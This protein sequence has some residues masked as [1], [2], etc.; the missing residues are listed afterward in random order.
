MASR[1]KKPIKIAQLRQKLDLL[2][3][4]GRVVG[5]AAFGRLFKSDAK[6][7][8]LSGKTIRLWVDGEGTRDR[9]MVPEHN[10]GRFVEIFQK[11]LPGSDPT[12]NI[13]VTDQPERESSRIC[14]SVNR[15]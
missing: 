3:E 8:G 7:E 6:P 1:Y 11:N 9:N 10:F 14:F 15:A 2:Y 13:C 4:S 12:P 5:D